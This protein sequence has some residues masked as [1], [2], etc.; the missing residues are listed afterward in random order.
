MFYY[1]HYTHMDAIQYV[2][3]DVPSDYLHY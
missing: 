3:I 1:T 2:Y